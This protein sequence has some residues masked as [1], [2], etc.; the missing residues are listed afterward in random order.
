MTATGAIFPEKFAN[1]I[2]RNEQKKK[3]LSQATSFINKQKQTE[4]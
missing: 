3:I 1:E 2:T 4:E